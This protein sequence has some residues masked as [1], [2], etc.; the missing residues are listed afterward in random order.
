MAKKNNY[1]MY[2]PWIIAIL[3]VGALFLAYNQGWINLNKQIE[4]EPD[5]TVY[6]SCSSLC[7]S[8]DFTSGYSSASC[9]TGETEIVYGYPGDTPL[10]ECCCF[11]VEDDEIN[12]DCEDS[13]GGIDIYTPG[14]VSA[15]D[16]S[17]YDECIDKT[18]IN[19]FSCD[20][21]NIIKTTTQACPLGYE[22]F[23]TR[24]GGYCM[25]VSSSWNPGDT[26]A[27]GGGSGIITGPD[28]AIS[29]LDLNDYGFTTDGTCRLGVQFST[30]WNYANEFC[31]GIMGAEGLV[32][33]LY[34]SAGLEYTRTDMVPVSLG[35]N[36]HPSA[37]NFDWDGVTPW[38]GQVIKTLGLPDC[39]IEY[40][41]TIR[42]YIYDC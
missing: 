28:T 30:S 15:F 18:L 32:W 19:E 41:Y 25:A 22:C 21:N 24:S 4:V 23:A 40:E 16:K 39:A 26:V 10:L 29:E 3:I 31:Q 7:V 8:K 35:A 42:I 14:Y 5:D 34:D 37:Y 1:K 20:A 33:N 17:F 36:L 11:E 13:D 38:R 12:G 2:A 9:N 27:E 6:A